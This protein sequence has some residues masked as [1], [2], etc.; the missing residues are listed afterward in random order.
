MEEFSKKPM[1]EFFKKSSK[2]LL[3]KFGEAS[4]EKCTGRHSH[5]EFLDECL[6]K[7]L[8][9]SNLPILSA[10]CCS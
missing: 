6:E 9:Y 8:E 10:P 4:H 5:V 1:P 3:E 2:K 7:L